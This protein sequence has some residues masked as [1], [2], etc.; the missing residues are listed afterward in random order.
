MLVTENIGLADVDNSRKL[1]RFCVRLIKFIIYLKTGL[2]YK[3]RIS[4]RL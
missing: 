1:T 3:F 2:A 4:K